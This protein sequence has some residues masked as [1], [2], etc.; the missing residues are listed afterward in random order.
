MSWSSDVAG[1][2]ITNV[3]IFVFT[4]YV[5]NRFGIAKWLVRIW[6]RIKNSDVFVKIN[7]VYESNVPFENLKGFIKDSFREQSKNLSVKKDS[8]QSL[9]FMVDDSYQISVYN[10]PNNEVSILTNKIKSTMQGVTKDV[11]KILN[12]LDNCKEKVKEWNFEEKEFSLYLHLPQEDPFTKIYPPR[13]I[14]LKDYEIE[15][16]HAGS[17]IKLKAKKVLNIHAKNR[18]SL[19]EIIRYFV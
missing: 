7:V 19:E 16:S 11:Q 4:I 6:H 2:A 1:S 10:Q 5:E 12:V 9:E 14:E 18:H 13:D 17:I 3:I 8:S 15:F